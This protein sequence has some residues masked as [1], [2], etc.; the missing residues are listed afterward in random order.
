M[1]NSVVTPK[2][3]TQFEREGYFL[4]ENVV[5]PEHLQLLR[6]KVLEN[7][8]RIDAQMDA[9]GVEK[10]GINHK[11]SRY[12]VSPYIAGDKELGDFIFSDLMAEVTRATLGDDV[13]LFYEQYVVKAAEKGGK[14]SWHQDSGYIGHPHHKPY[15]TCWITRD[16]VNEENG[17]VYLLP[18]DRAG[19][20]DFVPHRPDAE[21]G[22]KVGYFGD[23]PGLPIIAHAGSIACFSSTVFHRSGPNAT[24]K[25]RRIYL[26]QYSAEPLM[27]ADGTQLWNM[28]E[29]FI[30]N[31]VR[32]RFGA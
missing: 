32:V 9:L 25:M 19:T 22:D 29:P 16:D 21:S 24:N 2:N 8:Q 15:L 20:R 17:T 13:F 26:P 27:N 5:P 7:I 14:F 4:L 10:S 30:Q 23:D 12:F 1:S 3:R 28:A 31:G 6:G 18:Y 11:G